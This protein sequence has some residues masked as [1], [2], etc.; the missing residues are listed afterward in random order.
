MD[1]TAKKTI[2]LVIGNAAAVQL[3]V[4]GRDLGSP[5][6]PGEVVRLDFGPG[7]PTAAG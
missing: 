6:R 5:G 4:N 2:H 1:F 3:V 7:D